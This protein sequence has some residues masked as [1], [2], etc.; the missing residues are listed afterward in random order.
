MVVE[1]IHRQTKFFYCQSKKKR[2]HLFYEL[3]GN[4]RHSVNQLSESGVYSAS[5]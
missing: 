1:N 2:E 3:F 4:N 5:N